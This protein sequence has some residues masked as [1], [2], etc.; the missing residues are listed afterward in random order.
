LISFEISGKKKIIR[1]DQ[2]GKKKG[3]KSVD[4]L[5]TWNN[6]LPKQKQQKRLKLFS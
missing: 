1:Q 4:R 6:L 3:R 2:S 5:M